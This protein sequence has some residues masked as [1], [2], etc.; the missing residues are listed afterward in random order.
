MIE[1]KYL[2]NTYEVLHYG[3]EEENYVGMGLSIRHGNEVTDEYAAV[4]W[5]R[6]G[7]DGY[8]VGL[9]IIIH[10]Y[11]PDSMRYSMLV[12]RQSNSLLT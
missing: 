9:N 10:L 6:V 2:K 7:E 1:D 5:I 11:I 12:K 8:P 3:D 4:N